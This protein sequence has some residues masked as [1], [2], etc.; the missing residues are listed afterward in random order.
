MI[1]SCSS[2][3]KGIAAYTDQTVT[4]GKKFQYNKVLFPPKVFIVC[5]IRSIIG[6]GKVILLTETLLI[7]IDE[8]AVK[9]FLKGLQNVQIFCGKK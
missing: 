6:N 5:T 2:T 4:T 7:C 9:H 8:P 3:I 1:L